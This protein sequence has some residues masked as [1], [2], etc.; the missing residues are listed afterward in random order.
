MIQLTRMTLARAL[1]ACCINT[2]NKI[3]HAATALDMD[4][5]T[6]RSAWSANKRS[7]MSWD[8]VI[9]TFNRLGYDVFFT[10]RKKGSTYNDT[11]NQRL[12]TTSNREQCNRQSQ[13]THSIE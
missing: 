6:L 13:N 11:S 1:R 2:H 12:P 10:I 8:R 7:R 3:S 4:D 9:S 5:N